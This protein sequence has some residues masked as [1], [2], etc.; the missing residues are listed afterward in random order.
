MVIEKLG[1]YIVVEELG[2]GAMGVVYK[3]VDPLIDRTVAIKTINLDLSRDEL[4]TFEK[5]FQREVQSAGKLNHPNIV[6]IY[7]VG[8]AEGVAYMAMEFLEGKELREILDSGVVLPLDKVVHIAAQVCDGLAFAHEH[9]IVHRDIKPANIMVMKN[10]MVKITDFG[11]AQVSSASR[12]MAGMVMGSPKYMSPEQVVGQTVDGRSDIFSLGVVLY[13]MLTGKT[14][15]VGDN[16]SAIMYQI[17]NE[18]PIPPKAFNQNVPDSLNYIV[19]KALAKHPDARYQT[20]K[21]MAR[22]LRKYKTLQ[23]PA[24]GETPP[25]APM[26]RRKTPRNSL[27]DATQVI[28]RLSDDGAPAAPT[29]APGI[30]AVHWPRWALL[31]G[32]PL[33]FAV[34]VAVVLSRSPGSPAPAGAP[35]QPAAPVQS[36]AAP[37]AAAPP[38][39]LATAPGQTT[40]AT[41]PDAR[42]EERSEPAAV[43]ARPQPTPERQ[44]KPAAPARLKA[45]PLTSTAQ[46]RVVE[47]AA[48]PITASGT[49]Q[50]AIAPWGEVFVDGVR[51]GVSPPLR[52]IKLPPGDH[53]I[54]VVNQTF[55]PYSQ[56][57]RV[58]AGGTYKIKYKFNK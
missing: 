32:V 8:R 15:F 45:A 27:G 30:S 22:D 14:P 58:E 9:G 35:A 1:R 29:P 19:L 43:S 51:Q 38:H 36:P 40:P 10:G 26:E 31:A 25:A 21:E 24:P 37:A 16:I 20:A 2:Q 7:D 55:A 3:A 47:E 46:T 44:A 53:T 18:E 34:F 54:L 17:L 49:L 4:E 28:A 13:E 52:E 57:M 50:L 48:T 11:I 23:I 56:T 41:P 33:L 42:R 39:A 12:T 5:R 6:T